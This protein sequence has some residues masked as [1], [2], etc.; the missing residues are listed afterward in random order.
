MG[1]FVLDW[2]L[3]CRGSEAVKMYFQLCINRFVLIYDFMIVYVSYVDH[4]IWLENHSKC[5][6]II[7]IPWLVFFIDF[8]FIQCINK[9]HCY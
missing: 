8:I 3:V 4:P 7:G 2:L 5:Y 9:L 6:G 1:N